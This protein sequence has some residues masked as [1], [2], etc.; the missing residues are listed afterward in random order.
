MK[1][2]SRARGFFLAVCAA[3]C[4][5]AIFVSAPARA[6]EYSVVT[7]REYDHLAAHPQIFDE[8]R[9]T[10]VKWIRVAFETG[11]DLRKLATYKK[12]VA[13][14][15]A[16]GLR[17]LG[18]LD[19]L[20]TPFDENTDTQAY[21]DRYVADVIAHIKAVPEVSVWEIW[22]EP[23]NFGFPKDPSRYAPLLIQT[24]ERVRAAR[25]R[26]E[27]PAATRLV[28][29][30]VVDTRMAAIVFDA[31]EMRAYRAK[32]GGNVPF[33]IANYHP[34]SLGDPH[35]QAPAQ[36]GGFR[37]GMMLR[38]WFQKISTMRGA[39]GKFLFGDK[40]FWFTEF[41]FATQ[42]FGMDG[43]RVAFE[44]FAEDARFMPRLKNVF[45]YSYYDTGSTHGLRTA[46][47][48][49]QPSGTPKPIYFA[50][51]KAATRGAGFVAAA[52]KP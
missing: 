48:A 11:G 2:T 29:A 37:E 1:I 19:M 22:N 52:R 45:W 12:V 28:C 7:G 35:H 23:E 27:I 38:Q 40:P 31:P 25:N 47:T 43:A 33:D 4:L 20:S 18:L 34:Y 50:F 9:A 8:M 17:T 32:H 36:P 3:L 44:H 46:P 6:T 5:S 10:G 30:G 41:S 42:E 26:S 14:A 24:Y 51:K 49:A 15:K 21:R 39:D 16:R 13:L